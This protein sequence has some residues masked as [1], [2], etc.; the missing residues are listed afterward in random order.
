M[1]KVEIEV[2]AK[3]F[4]ICEEIADIND[5]FSISDLR[6][7]SLRQLETLMSRVGP[8]YQY[9]IVAA[10]EGSL[11]WTQIVDQA[12]LSADPIWDEGKALLARRSA[13]QREASERLAASTVLESEWCSSFDECLENLK[14]VVSPEE[15]AKA[16]S[17][18][19][20][21]RNR[22]RKVSPRTQL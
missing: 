4:A 17:P 18:R 22:K 2:Y 14:V 20:S 13:A 15:K 10:L 6:K 16:L 12:V 21:R 7:L 5:D 19:T 11:L 3:L 9:V 1:T 8:T